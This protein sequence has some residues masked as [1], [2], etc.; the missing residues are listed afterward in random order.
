MY[1]RHPLNRRC[2]VP[3][4]VH[5]HLPCPDTITVNVASTKGG[6]HARCVTECT[7]PGDIIGHHAA[8]TWAL[9]ASSA[10]GLG[11]GCGGMPH[12]CH[13]CCRHIN[14]HGRRIIERKQERV[15]VLMGMDNLKPD[16]H[17]LHYTP[18]CDTDTEWSTAPSRV[19]SP[20]PTR[21]AHHTRNWGMQWSG[22]RGMH[23]TSTRHKKGLL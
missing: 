17:I 22:E 14:E 10:N 23:A 18:V 1:R 4:D 16:A 13:A 11:L 5:V 9:C 8:T 7:G 12:T 2:T 6:G 21:P 20:P 3:I 15:E 19:R